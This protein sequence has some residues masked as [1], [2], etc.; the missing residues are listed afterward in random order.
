M[1]IRTS[2]DRIYRAMTVMEQ[3]V[4][5]NRGTVDLTY[6]EMMY[7]YLIDMT[8]DCTVSKLADMI[9]VSLPA[10]TKRINSLEERGLVQRTRSEGDGRVKTVTLS[11]RGAALSKRMDDLFYPILDRF[12]ERFPQEDVARFCMMLDMLSD[13]I[14]GAIR[15]S[16]Q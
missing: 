6:K 2:F 10:V 11:E 7:L 16:A 3:C 8:P 14:E 5:E 15:G 4:D 9:N 1:T 12:A 13:D